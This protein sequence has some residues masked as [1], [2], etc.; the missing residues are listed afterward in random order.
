MFARIDQSKRGQDMTRRDV[1]KLISATGMGLT[2]G[3]YLPVSSAAAMDSAMKA[4]GSLEPNAFVRIT[5]DN[6]VTVIIKHLEMGQGTFTGLATL[7]AEELDA[8]WSQI[9]AEPAPA[10]V[11][12]YN[13]LLWG[14][15]QGTG[16]S[17]AIANAYEQMRK[18][19]A[20][21]KMMLVAAAA[22]QWAVDT[23]QIAI[24]QGVVHHKASDKQA[25]FGQLAALAAAMPMPQPEE[26][27]L[28]DPKDFKLI[29]KQSL[30]RKDVGKEDGSAIF[31]QDIQLPGM[32]TAVITHPPRFGAKLKTVDASQT[33][34]EQGVVDVVTIPD[35]IAVVAEDFWSAQS[36]RK[37]LNIE[38]DE[39]QAF[40]KSSKELQADY[41]ELAKKPGL[42][43]RQDGDTGAALEKASQVLESHY[44]FPFLAHAAM[45]PMNC[46]AKVTQEGCEIWNGEQLQTPDQ[47]N[48]AQALGIKPEQVKIN[49][50][51]AGGSFGRRANPMSDYVIEAVL[52][53]KTRPGTPVKLVWTREEDTQGGYYRPMYYHKLRA[54]LDM[55]GNPV[56]WEQR[57]VGQSILKNTPFEGFLVKDGIDAT[58]VEGAS[59][60]PYSIPNIHVDVHNVELPVPVLW[61]RSV[62][63][64]HTAF[65]TE[66]FI[67]ELA[68]TAKQDPVA[69]R[70]R[71][72]K[73]HPRLQG[74]LKL[75]AEKA[76]WG[77]PP[78]KGRGR[79]V[80]L[81][82]SF[83]SFAA[84]VA[85]VS[86]TEDKEIKVE[87]VVCAID[88]GL[89][90]NPDII[91]AQMEGSI[92]FGLGPA[93]MSAIT[94]KQGK[95]V[96][97]NFDGYEVLTM[98]KMPEVEVH[99]VPSSAPPTGVGEPGVP[100]IAPAV[101][102]ALSAL[103]G[104][105]FHQLPLKLS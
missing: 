20:A 39:S 22:K 58:S 76:G 15:M 49:M 64:T 67:D 63:H 36:A 56:A 87:R 26:I 45:E 4:N 71:L 101:A 98:D 37:K 6:R 52:I 27:T 30:P 3:V 19:G 28:K 43:A 47:T 102:N 57:I 73:G 89:A 40:N 25:T 105:R 12:R 99:I 60:L 77:S 5:P 18:A 84:Q 104:Q 10:D 50:L 48:I 66:V 95:V 24:H 29:G 85:E 94:F 35:G 93:L 34:A 44:S 33:L 7:V 91:K 8:D 79:G 83:S 59:T 42:V 88:C 9:V 97:N 92:A 53:A 69:Y 103:T 38:W 80:A 86:I 14:P 13:N 51:Y 32:L 21:A 1:L 23:G 82:E 55:D 81:Q 72:L 54:G 65:S 68:R 17:T 46:V 41:M 31:T 11:K 90:I 2:L 100:P 16:G 96:E 74:V 62:G 75:A 70:M 61:L 78:P